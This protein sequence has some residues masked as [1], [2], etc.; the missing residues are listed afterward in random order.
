MISY[1]GSLVQFSPAAGRAGR[2]R[3]TSLCVGSTRRVLARQPE[4]LAASPR[5]PLRAAR[6]AEAWR[7]F[8]PRP[9]RAPPVGSQEVFRPE[10][11]PVCRVGGGGFSGAEFAPCPSPCLLPPAGMGLL[12]SGVSQSLC[13]ANRRRCVLARQP[14]VLAASPQVLRAASPRPPP[15]AARAARGLCALSTVMPRLFPP[16]PQRA[17]PVGSQEV[18]DRNRSLFARWEGVA[19]LG[20]SLPLSPPPPSYLQ[21]GSGGSSLEF[22]SP[23]VLRTA[24]GVFRPVNFSLALPQFKKSSLRLLAGPLAGPYPKECCRLLSVPPPL[25]GG[26]CGRLGYFSA[27]SC[28]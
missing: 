5:S 22:L 15:R 11:G 8:P 17:P 18:L 27:G 23:C 20:L 26:G 12:F 14:A 25:A 3:Q 13:F 24:G 6:A 9:Q 4:V 28:F 7:L 21:R 1:L 16:R 10:P 2:C 19:S